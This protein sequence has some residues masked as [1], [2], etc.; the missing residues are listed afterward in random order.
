MIASIIIDL[1]NAF[2]SPNALLLAKIFNSGQYVRLSQVNKL[3][4]DGGGIRINSILDPLWPSPTHDL[5]LG[6]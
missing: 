2:K 1:K 5:D 3:D 4:T 6:F